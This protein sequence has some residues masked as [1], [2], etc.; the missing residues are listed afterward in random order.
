LTPNPPPPEHPA[1]NMDPGPKPGEVFGTAPLLNEG[2]PSPAG[3]V[4]MPQEPEPRRTPSHRTADGSYFWY[5]FKSLYGPFKFVIIFGVVG[6]LLAIP[7]IVIDPDAIMA[8][9]ELGDIDA[10]FAQQTRQVLYYIFAWLMMSWLGL[11][12]SFAVGSAL[13]YVFRFVARYVDHL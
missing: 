12:L 3:T 6:V 10:F 7:V 13:P 11:A 5:L 4:T 9:A 8:K 2:K 1:T